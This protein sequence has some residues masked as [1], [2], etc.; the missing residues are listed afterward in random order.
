MTIVVGNVHFHGRARAACTQSVAFHRMGRA[1]AKACSK[2]GRKMECGANRE[3]SSDSGSSGAPRQLFA[4]MWPSGGQE[5]LPLCA[6]FAEISSD[7]SEPVQRSILSQVCVCL[8][9]RF[10][11]QRFVQCRNL[12]LS[13]GKWNITSLPKTMLC[14]EKTCALL[15]RLTLCGIMQPPG[16]WTTQLLRL[17]CC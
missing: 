11:C 4:D 5:A 3:D 17:C 12:C 8:T 10:C 6:L 2:P 13:Q 7:T 1:P 14:K 9:W 15:C 16:L